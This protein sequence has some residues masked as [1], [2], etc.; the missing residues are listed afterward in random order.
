MSDVVGLTVRL[1]SP[2]NVRLS[3]Q[4]A[5]PG[6][7]SAA[8]GIDYL[9]RA[10]LLFA[11]I[12]FSCVLAAFLPGLSMGGLLL[13]LFFVE[14]LYYILQEGLCNGVTIGKWATGLRVIHTNGAPLTFWGAVLRNLLRVADMLPIAM[15]FEEMAWIGILPL[16]GPGLAAMLLTRRFQRL[17]DLA[18]QTMVVQIHP[19]TMPLEPMILDHIAPIERQE[20]NG[21][22]PS[23][24]Q[25]ST[26]RQFL[27]RRSRLTYQRG[28]QL[29]SELTSALVDRMEFQGDPEN[30]RKFP[31]AFLARVCA[32]F[33][34]PSAISGENISRD[35]RSYP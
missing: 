34:R 23:Q 2:E 28:H 19:L 13:A 4:L 9:C 18:A 15:V 6:L 31:M 26:I 12:L 16:Y 30:A 25:L 11:L 21:F 35:T 17:G 20:R 14:W 10:A 22:V 5:G 7:R 27:G 1:E 32:T 3:H 8:Y 29:S 24:R 33:Q